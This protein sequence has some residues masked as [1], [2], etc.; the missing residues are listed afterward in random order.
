MGKWDDITEFE[1]GQLLQYRYWVSQ[2]DVD[3]TAKQV[4]ITVVDDMLSELKKRPRSPPL[5]GHSKIKEEELLEYADSLEKSDMPG[6]TKGLLYFFIDA[7]IRD[8]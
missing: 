3:E 7:V 6:H 2:Q 8:I 1:M 4:V 5:D